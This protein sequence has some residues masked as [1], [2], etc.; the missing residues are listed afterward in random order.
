M[1]KH[2]ILTLIFLL[3]A[4]VCFA[5]VDSPKRSTFNIGTFVGIGGTSITP[6]P[7]LDLRYRGTT[8]RLAPG[9]MY[10]GIGIAQEL[11]PISRSF[12]NVYWLASVYYVQGTQALRPNVTTDYTSIS[13]L[14]GI[15]YYMGTRFFSEL[16]LGIENR[17]KTT[18]GFET[19][20]KISPY[21]EFGIGVNLFRNFPEKSIKI[22]ADE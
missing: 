22:N 9:Y 18:P 8:L 1:P 11:F 15:K 20:N 6:I 14:A 21:F 7:T 3:S 5:Q 13:G 12:Y 4:S 2:N 17:K 10:N 19:I 16:Q